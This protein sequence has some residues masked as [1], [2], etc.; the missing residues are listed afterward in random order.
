MQAQLDAPEE[1]IDELEA[2]V[3]LANTD[4]AVVTA[5][6]SSAAMCSSS[7]TAES[8]ASSSTAAVIATAS[9]VQSEPVVAHAAP[10]SAGEA[11]VA[12]SSAQAPA[13]VQSST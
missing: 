10:A 3:E 1:D 7:S 11:N 12:P 9:H 6:T 2:L 5:A 4:E 8:S 13:A